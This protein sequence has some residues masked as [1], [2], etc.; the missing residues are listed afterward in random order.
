MGEFTTADDWSERVAARMEDPE[1]FL[2]EIRELREDPTSHPMVEFRVAATDATYQRFV[3]PISGPDGEVIGTVRLLR[4]MTAERA[5]ERAKD[6][7]MAAVSHELRTPLASILGFAELLE[8][9]QLDDAVQ[10]RYAGTIHQEARRLT[11]LVDDLI[12]LRLVE[13]GRLALTTEPV[14]V[15][16]LVREQA[17]LFARRADHHSIDVDVADGPLVARGD[18]L[19]LAQVFSNLLSNAIK[20][21]PGRRCGARRRDGGQRQRARLRRRRGH[22]HP[23]R[24]AVAPLR[25]LLPRRPPVHPPHRRQRHRPGPDARARARPGRRDRVREHRGRRARRS[26]STSRSAAPARG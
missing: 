1:R 16:E 26:G 11:A 5:A 25:A 8:T 2:R 13:E 20:Y 15:G 7:L 21:S 18:R 22:R 14:D 24:A 17:A 10:R 4:D 12:D 19:R 3:R 6:D 9:R 23:G